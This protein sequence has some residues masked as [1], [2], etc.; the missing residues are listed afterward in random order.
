MP[1]IVPIDFVC[2]TMVLRD[3]LMV[4]KK[5]ETHSSPVVDWLALFHKKRN[6][7]VLS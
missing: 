2:K 1:R 4:T 5:T 6:V 7:P 3:T